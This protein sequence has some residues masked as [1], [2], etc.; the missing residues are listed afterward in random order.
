MNYRMLNE[1]YHQLG[2]KRFTMLMVNEMILGGKLPKEELSIKALWEAMDRPDLNRG[3]RLLSL[4]LTDAEFAEAMDS[5][6]FPKITGALISKFVQ[7]GYDLEF[8]IADQLVTVIPSSQKDDIVV[9]F[10]AEDTLEEVVEGMPYSEGAFGEKY[11]KV[12]N[13]KWGRI[14]SL[15]EEMVKFDQTGQMIQR[16]NRIGQQARSRREEI[17][18]KVIIGDTNTGVTAS[19][20]PGGT[21]TTLFSDTSTDP[22]DNAG[23]TFDNVNTNALTDETD[24]DENMAMLGAAKDENG[25]PIVIMPT[26][27]LTTPGK[28]AVARRIVESPMAKEKTLPSGIVNVYRGL[29]EPVASPWVTSELG[30]NYWLLGAFKKQYVYSEVFPLQTMQ[31]KPGNDEEFE[32]DVIMRVKARFM[33]GCAAVS[34]KFVIRS[35]G[36]S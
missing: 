32:R 24:V 3:R 4:R 2:E 8:G 35:T 34:N 19:W 6:A 9:G 26:H 25:R 13:R 15:T 17:I 16:A 11:H 10:T 5:S 18:I 33:G 23:N 31:A 27:I 1:L 30:T 29:V 28:I 12:Y 20:R 7:D 36:A 14:L 22:Y 21:A